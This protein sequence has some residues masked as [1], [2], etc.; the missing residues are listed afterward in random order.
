[1]DRMSKVRLVSRDW[2]SIARKFARVGTQ[3]AERRVG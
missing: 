1:M 3:A 2:P